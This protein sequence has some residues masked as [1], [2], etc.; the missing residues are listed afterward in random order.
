MDNMENFTEFKPIYE[1]LEKNATDYRYSHQIG[2]LFQ[3]LRDLKY[4]ENKPD[5][6]EKAQWEIDFFNFTIKEG[7]LNPKFTGT[8][9][10]GEVVKYPTLDR[11]DNR[12]Y[13][14]LI[15]RLN[16]TSNPLLKARYSHILWYS[17]KK[18]TKYAKIVI[19]S[20]LKLIKIYEIKDVKDVEKHYGLD[21]MNMIK[22]AYSLLSFTSVFTSFFE[23]SC[24]TSGAV[25]TSGV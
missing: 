12:A 20:H 21:V 25:A 6:A 16:S 1:Y 11:F 23:V 18:H 24:T 8:N 15:E 7:N 10:K 9:E 5:E 17:P 13:D 3:R 4:K 22:N 14:Y 19:D 2:N